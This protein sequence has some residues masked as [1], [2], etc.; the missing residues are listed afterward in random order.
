MN[1][2]DLKLASGMFKG[3]IPM[4]LPYTPGGELSGIVEEVPPDVTGLKKGTRSSA[5]A[6]RGDYAEFVAAPADTVAFKPVKLSF[7]EAACVPVAGQ[8]AW[9]GLFD[10]GEFKRGQTVLVHAAAGGVGTYAVRLAKWPAPP[11]PRHRL[12][13]GHRVRQPPRGGRGDRLQDHV[14]ETVAKDVDLVLDLLG[15]DTQGA[16]VRS[17]QEQR[18]T[19][20]DRSATVAGP[21][22][23]ARACR[24]AFFSM[25]PSSAGLIRL[26][27]LID[28]GA[29]KV[30]VA[31]TYPPRD[32]ATAC[33]ESGHARKDGPGGLSR[34]T[35]R[36]RG[37]SRALR[38]TLHSHRAREGQSLVPDDHRVGPDRG[39][40]R[41]VSRNP[42]SRIQPRQSAA[43]V[44]EPARRLDQHVQAHQQAE[45]VAPGARRR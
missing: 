16:V 35:Q 28:Q 18:S 26:A 37:L 1:P 41:R 39:A 13:R 2:F 32:A 17:A 38:R 12:R 24:A 6:R 8:T 10:Q 22:R 14:F 9:Q 7:I 43:G 36:A 5:I 42:A 44:V 15:G 21:G 31:K 20:L 30:V 33:A 34:K 29:V 19:R 4:T 25:K 23:P 40:R 11:L 27:E 45:R 3:M